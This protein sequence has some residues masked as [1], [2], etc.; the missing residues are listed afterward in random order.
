[1]R[2]RKTRASAAL[3]AVTATLLLSACGGDE[4]GDSGEAGT[5]PTTTS[6]QAPDPAS[7]TPEQRA[8]IAQADAI[9]RRGD[10]A[11]DKAGQ[12]FAGT[13]GEKVDELVRTVIVPGTQKEIEQLRALEPPP[14]DTEQVN[15]FIDTLEQG[16]DQLAADPRQLAGGE[17]LQTIIEARKLAFEY[18]MVD[19]A[20]S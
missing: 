12:R 13:S 5:E 1:M 20:R 16:F 14:G 8:F 17:A 15:A 11:I 2:D 4:G 6:A 19:C 9:C 18:G 7:L 3:L 10:A